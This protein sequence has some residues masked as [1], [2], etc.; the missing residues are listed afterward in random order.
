MFTAGAAPW[1]CGRDADAW[2]A[3]SV[4]WSTLDFSSGH[5]PRAMGLSLPLDSSLSMEPA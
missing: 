2:V 4:E 3:Q 1:E 5:D